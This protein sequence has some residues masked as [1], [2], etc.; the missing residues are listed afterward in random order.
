MRTLPILRRELLTT[1]R[2]RQAFLILLAYVFVLSIVFCAAWPKTDDF[3]RDRK[4]TAR[5]LFGTFALTQLML[6]VLLAPAVTAPAVSGEREA[7]TLELLVTSGL[8]P[9][10]VI[11]G[12]FF[13]G[14]LFLLF[15]LVA[16]LPPLSLV[17]LLGGV[18]PAEVLLVYSMLLSSTLIFGMVGTVCSCFSQRTHNALLMAYGLI[19]VVPLLWEL[20][21]LLTLLALV[22]AFV[23]PLLLVSFVGMFAP[24][25]FIQSMFGGGT[26]YE[27]PWI[28]GLAIAYLLLTL[29]MVHFLY[30]L[31]LWRFGRPDQGR[32]RRLRR[33][34][35][36]DRADRAEPASNDAADEVDFRPIPSYA[37]PVYTKDRRTQPLGS[38]R[39]LLLATG[40][41][42][43][44]ASVFVLLGGRSL[45]GGGL[46]DVVLAGYALVGL[47]VAFLA[48][49]ITASTAIFTERENRRLDLLYI[50]LV[51]P[52]RMLAAKFRLCLRT[53]LV[54]GGA[55]VLLGCWCSVIFNSWHSS[56]AT[57]VLWKT[58]ATVAHFLVT[59][60][61]LVALSLAIAAWA[62]SRFRALVVSYGLVFVMAA[63]YQ[64]LQP[65]LNS[66]ARSVALPR[67]VL[68]WVFPALVDV[69]SPWW[70]ITTLFKPE[71][72]PGTSEAVRL[73]L[74]L[75]VYGVVLVV[76]LLVAHHR[77]APD[78]DVKRRWWGARRTQE[79][80]RE[81]GEP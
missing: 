51:T 74:V 2:G 20:G 39:A 67:A 30:R 76:S 29:V 3:I 6:I 54:L 49:P 47:A 23:A 15:L 42:A 22:I 9:E 52:A 38:W 13:S 7:K 45:L 63:S 32:L 44:A 56:P 16:S 17:F 60:T 70:F 8:G 41:L 21:P 62:R 72:G 5:S 36:R 77:L 75:S 64:V 35:L 4:E 81:G 18:S 12:K 25:K 10:A 71:L 40:G 66:V 27:T 69:L 33:R 19:V 26:Q 78:A 24:Y 46:R 34:W 48:A 11:R 59:S 53:V 37:D 68:D 55:L 43:G 57:S 1:L 80:V 65:L 58:G 61:A 31:A 28:V 14:I 73:A 79:L 50:T